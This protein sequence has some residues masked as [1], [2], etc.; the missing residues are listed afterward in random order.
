[1]KRFL[2]PALRL[3]LGL[4]FVAKAGQCGLAAAGKRIRKLP[5]KV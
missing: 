5:L 4:I 3:L 2:A 1:M